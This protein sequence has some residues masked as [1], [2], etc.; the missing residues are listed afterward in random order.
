MLSC[1]QDKYHIASHYI[2]IYFSKMQLSCTTTCGQYSAVQI[3]EHFHNHTFY[4]D[5]DLAQL[6]E[7]KQACLAVSHNREDKL[8]CPMVLADVGKDRGWK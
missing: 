5:K 6:P 2:S 7:I 8:E 3:I 4:W 1:Q